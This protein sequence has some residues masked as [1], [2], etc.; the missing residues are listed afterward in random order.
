MPDLDSPLL[1]SLKASAHLT[2]DGST[3]TIERAIARGELDARKVGRR[4]M[5]VAASLRKWVETLPVAVL[6]EPKPRRP[7]TA[8]AG[9]AA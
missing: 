1:L 4:T 8:R 2:G 6:K 3:D 9:R 7:D 5:V